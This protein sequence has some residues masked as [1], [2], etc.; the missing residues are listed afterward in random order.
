MKNG[1]KFILLL[2]IVSIVIISG[3][4]KSGDDSADDSTTS[5]TIKAVTIV[6]IT[7]R[8]IN[9]QPPPCRTPKET[10]TEIKIPPKIGDKFILSV[11]PWLT[12]PR[13]PETD[14]GGPEITV[15]IGGK[16]LPLQGGK[17]IK[18][19]RQFLVCIN[20][21]KE[22]LPATVGGLSGQIV[23]KVPGLNGGLTGFDIVGGEVSIDITSSSAGGESLC[24]KFGDYTGGILENLLTASQSQLDNLVISKYGN[25]FFLLDKA[26]GNVL[27]HDSSNV[28]SS[29]FNSKGQN[30]KTESYVPIDN[31]NEI[32]F[33]DTY[34][35]NGADPI[36][37]IRKIPYDPTGASL[38]PGF[39]YPPGK[40]LCNDKCR[41]EEYIPLN[42]TE[43]DLRG[44]PCDI[45]IDDPAGSKG[46]VE[47][48]VKIK[49]PVT[50]E[51]TET[52]ENIPKE[53]FVFVDPVQTAK[54]TETLPPSLPS[55]APT[56]TT[57]VPPDAVVFSSDYVIDSLT[58][59]DI[60]N[61]EKTIY[62]IK[63]NNSGAG[64]VLIKEIRVVDGGTAAKTIKEYK[65]YQG[66]QIVATAVAEA[67]GDIIFPLTGGGSKVSPSQ[68][69]TIDLN[70]KVTSASGSGTT[71]PSLASVQ[72]VSGKEEIKI[73]S[74]KIIL[75]TSSPKPKTIKKCP[76]DPVST[77]VPT[78]LTTTP[79]PTTTTGPTPNPV[80]TATPT[81]SA[82][83]TPKDVNPT[84]TSSACTPNW[85][86]GSWSCSCANT[87]TRT[88]TDSNNCGTT[89]GKPSESSGS[90]CT[91]RTY[92]EAS[93]FNQPNTV[94]I[95][96]GETKTFTFSAASETKNYAFTMPNRESYTVTVTPTLNTIGVNILPK[97]KQ[98]EYLTEVWH[99]NIYPVQKNTFSG[100]P[101][102]VCGDQQQVLVMLQPGSGWN[103]ASGT[104]V[105][106][107]GT[108]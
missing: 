32:D 2:L 71:Q 75:P 72:V 40:S 24:P 61:K 78:S 15:T 94:S 34:N 48:Q 99:D 49:D 62:K 104:I 26:S 10:I 14:S 91:L 44:F 84:S 22:S 107:S 21:P 70:A 67:S 77:A 102:M 93:N 17:T 12:G 80:L 35:P 103:S 79:I 20:K 83:P 98:P 43:Y 47:I 100:G 106:N 42:N 76:P 82:T 37:D 27:R 46:D 38:P 81:A 63:V 7:S 64:E 4:V 11:D 69:L 31:P 50:Q 65:L 8:C 18:D 88:C 13:G 90:W 6:T 25:E 108:G 41:Q 97:Y 60:C 52:T 9:D 3:C 56:A 85:G 89:S 101:S 74:Q 19:R 29:S 87:E 58:E 51:E 53:N 16:Q 39:C 45:K 73:I 68:T 92:V 86:C 55:S 54:P 95:A 33:L 57:S 36:K 28:P 1:K 105:V 96:L 59:V 66:S 5:K 23:K 30:K